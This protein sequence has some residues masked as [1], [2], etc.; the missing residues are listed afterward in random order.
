VTPADIDRA[1]PVVVR[2]ECTIAAPA[3]ALWT[4]HTDVARWPEWQ[5]DIAS[6][7]I[8]GAFEPGATFSWVTEGLEEPIHSTIHAVGPCRSTLWGGPAAGIVGL[9]RWTF[10]PVASGT[11][12]LT[13]ES[14]AGEAAAADP[15]ALV[16]A[17]AR[18]LRRWLDYLEIAATDR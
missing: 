15:A 16:Q 13:E 5:Q 4:L 1:A 8:D 12:V 9:H 7:T 17:L 18:S 6:A 3:E 10:T 14:W 2:V 11:H